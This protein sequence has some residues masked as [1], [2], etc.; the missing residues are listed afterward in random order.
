MEL[1]NAGRFLIGCTKVLLVSFVV[2]TVADDY[3]HNLQS[4]QDKHPA[5]SLGEQVGA[6]IAKT[7][8]DFFPVNN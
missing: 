5:E 2:P 3:R 6:A 8:C 1:E 7:I 4:E